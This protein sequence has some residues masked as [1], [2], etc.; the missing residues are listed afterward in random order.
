M[1]Y[2]G[3]HNAKAEECTTLYMRQTVKINIGVGG[4]HG[5]LFAKNRPTKIIKLGILR[6][7]KQFTTY[8]LPFL[9]NTNTSETT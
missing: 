3:V 1:Y 8:L 5:N 2:V 9:M 4:L 6:I 7:R